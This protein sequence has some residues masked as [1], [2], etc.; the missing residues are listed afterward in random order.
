MNTPLTRH[1]YDRR[2]KSVMK[3]LRRYWWNATDS[4]AATFIVMIF[5]VIV[6]GWLIGRLAF[7][8]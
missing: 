4:G 7:S 3:R 5:I 2:S 6:M 1:R 8:R